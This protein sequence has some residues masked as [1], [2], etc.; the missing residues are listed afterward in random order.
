MDI[1]NNINLQNSMNIT[2]T[3]NN[4][5]VMPAFDLEAQKQEIAAK[6]KNSPEVQNIVR[7]I[8]ISNPNSI[9]TFGK[10]ATEEMSTTADKLLHQME[11]SKVEDSGQMLMQLKKI[12]DKFDIKELDADEK[13]GLFS[14]LFNSTKN[15]LEALF[16][17]YH[18]MGDEVDKI[19][20]TIKQYEAE[21]HK[22]NKNLDEM[23]IGNVECYEQLEKYI[24]AGELAIDH[25]NQNMLPEL[26]SKA[27]AGDE[28]DKLNLENMNRV[29]EML[30]QRVHDLKLAEHV[31]L[32]GMPDIKTMQYSNFSLIRKINSAF[33]ITLPVFK[34]C[35][36]KTIMLKRQKVQAKSLSALDDTTNELLLRNANT[37]AMQN[38]EIAKLSS[39]SSIEIE[40]L[41]KTWQTIVNGIEETKRIQEEAKQKRIDSNRRLEVLKEDYEKK[42]YLEQM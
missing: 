27:M 19:F 16:K 37:T 1:G 34:Q 40:T 36:V 31:A 20:V 8:D 35:L 24:Y 25:I 29:E 38:K 7:Q 26:Q 28:M 10:Q 4:E 33:I 5:V 11:I 2:N 21:I 39:G 15:T 9:L 6:I 23:F 30:E 3:V 32:Q 22:V 17:K 42:R 12:M 18:T 13:Q 14:K 41:E